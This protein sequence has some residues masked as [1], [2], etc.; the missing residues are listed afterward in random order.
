MLGHSKGDCIRASAK[1]LFRIW[2]S[3]SDMGRDLLAK[4]DRQGALMRN[5]KRPCRLRSREVPGR[6]DMGICAEAG[7]KVADNR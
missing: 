5:L 7:R 2:W 3:S 1:L 6:L 4:T